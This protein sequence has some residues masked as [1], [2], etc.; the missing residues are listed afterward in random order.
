M[1]V[2]EQSKAARLGF[3]H[4]LQH[5]ETVAGFASRLAWLNGRPVDALLRDMAIHPRMIDQ[6]DEKAIREIAYLGS[7]EADPLLFYSPRKI[8]QKTWAVA[9]R[10]VSRQ[11]ISRTYFRYCPC[12]ILEDLNEFDGPRHVR[13]WLRLEW[14][15]SW[16]RSCDRHGMPFVVTHP[17]R[18]PFAPFDFIET[19][20]PLLENVEREAQDVGM[21][22]ASAFQAW[23]MRRLDGDTADPNWLDALPLDAAADFCEALGVSAL[24]D[25]KVQ[26]SSLLEADWADAAE[27]G[28]A[29]AS[30]GP[31]SIRALL[32]R[33]NAREVDRRGYWTP[34]DTYGWCYHFLERT[35]D[36]PEFAEIRA[37]IRKAAVETMPLSAGTVVLGEIIED[38]QV[39]TLYSLARTA[40]IHKRTLRTILERR[41]PDSGQSDVSDNRLTVTTEIAADI[42]SGYKG[43]MTVPAVARMTGIEKRTLDTMIANGW[44]KTRSKSANVAFAKHRVG[45]EDVDAMFQAFFA[46]AE[47][48]DEPE[49]HQ[50]TLDFARQVALCSME[51]VLRVVFDGRL[52][53]KGRLADRHDY[54]AL[55]VDVDE[56]RANV[57]KGAEMKG[58]LADGVRDIIRGMDRKSIPI[59]VERGYLKASKEKHPVTGTTHRTISVESVQAFRDI[60]I[61]L[62]EM[63]QDTGLHRSQVGLIMRAHGIE[64]VFGVAEFWSVFY[65]RADV[66][67]AAKENPEF[68]RYDK[69]AL[70]R[71]VIGS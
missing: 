62:G 37:I 59:F 58:L 11:A 54:G 41:H 48:V 69:Q 10:N 6:G 29:I 18:R 19:M 23:F 28:F 57:P 13:P 22:P 20:R 25:P 8:T 44:L 71:K 21:W 3:A 52:T 68:W 65:R 50:V 40:G 49:P 5:R 51:E 27:E 67:S 1:S 4:A 36:R 56:V 47:P 15:L 39:H 60:Y 46:G 26:I 2:L 42:V 14:T 34:R 66:E 43:A 64:E 17:T 61:S 35:K 12:C 63:C 16:I 53:W 24:Q 55:L 31:D 70:K 33:L 9:G 32:D 7:A 30:E 38:Q 45:Q